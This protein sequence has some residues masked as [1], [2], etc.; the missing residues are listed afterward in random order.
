MFTYRWTHETFDKLIK[1]SKLH[2]PSID[3]VKIEIDRA[4]VSFTSI[5]LY[6]FCFFVSESSKCLCTVF[7]YYMRLI[8]I[9]PVFDFPTVSK[10]IFVQTIWLIT[11]FMSFYKFI[12]LN[13]I[14]SQWTKFV[15]SHFLEIRIQRVQKT[16]HRFK[17]LVAI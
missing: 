5:D 8:Y 3:G 12:D 9:V 15:I 2:C 16:R 11:N 4:I 10:S 17:I 14:L 7:I 6:F 13:T 1:F